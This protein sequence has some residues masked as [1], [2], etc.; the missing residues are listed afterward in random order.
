MARQAQHPRVTLARQASVLLV[1]SAPTRTGLGGN[2]QPAVHQAM[3]PAVQPPC[4]RPCNQPCNR[5]RFF[6]PQGN[7]PHFVFRAGSTRLR[8]S[9]RP[10]IHDP[11]PA[12]WALLAI[13]DPAHGPV[14]TRP[15]G[16]SSTTL[17]HPMRQVRPPARGAASAPPAAPHRS[18]LS[19]AA[20]APAL[21]RSAHDAHLCR[22][23]APRA[24]RHAPRATRRIRLPRTRQIQS[25]RRAPR[26]STCRALCPCAPVPLCPCAPVPL[27]PCALVPLCPCTPV[28]LSPPCARPGVS[29]RA[30]WSVSPAVAVLSCTLPPHQ[31]QCHPRDTSPL[32]PRGHVPPAA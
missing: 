15:T 24:T 23:H 25:P 7:M 1:Q 12:S 5:P 21:R 9:G 28:P 17:G 18:V 16:L 13:H 30:W 31:T 19:A 22:R 10:V 11:W 3:Q 32:L 14:G 6:G 27:C 29:A 4:N 8:L 26:Q 2:L 20:S